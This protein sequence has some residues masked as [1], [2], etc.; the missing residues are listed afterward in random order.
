[1]RN[2][3][4]YRPEIDSLRTIAVFG[5]IIYHLSPETLKGGFLGVD[6]FFVIS[7]YLITSIIHRQI[8]EGRFSFWS[9]WKRRFKRLYPAL[10]VVVLLSMVVGF[11]V[12]P[13]PERGALPMQ[14]LGALFSFSNILLWRTTG[15][16]WDTSS[17]T[18]SL[19]HTW[20]LSLEEQFYIFFP[21][22]LFLANIF[23]KKRLGLATVLLLITSLV[24]SMAFSYAKPTPSFYLLHT[25]MWEL[26]IGSLLAIYSPHLLRMIKS[27]SRGTLVH[28][29]GTLLIAGSYFLIENERGFP[30]LY[31]VVPC[32][33]AY[34]ILAFQ[35]QNS[36]VTRSLNFSPIVYLGK[37]SYSLY[38]WHWPIIVYAHYFSPK[39]SKYLVLA[40]TFL[41]AVI[42]YHFVEQP[43]R[44]APRLPRLPTLTT[45]VAIIV[46]LL[47]LNNF[48]QSPLLEGLKNFDSKE[49]FTR[50]HEF[51]ATE[52]ILKGNVVTSTKPEK[53][54]IVVLGSSH[55]RVLCG[56]IQKYA[57][58]NNYEFISLAASGIGI[59]TYS[60]Q[61]DVSSFAEEVNMKRAEIIE[62]IRPNVLVIAGKWSWSLRGEDRLSVLRELLNKAI[63]VSET[64]IVLAQVPLIELPDR[65]E[66][67]LRKFL[68]AQHLSGQSSRIIGSKLVDIANSEVRDVVQEI[69][70]N[71]L[72]FVDPTDLF[73]DEDHNLVIVNEEAGFLY[74]DYNHVN[75]QGARLIFDAHILPIMV[76]QGHG[77]TN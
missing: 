26:L 6:I 32:L 57:K 39:P 77:R 5:V 42:S 16:Y 31:A 65:Y 45:A 49:S 9:F 54:T 11:L 37:I 44:K 68:I 43:I 3:I 69:A 51:E 36:L 19:L 75:D 21:I 18:I 22:F 38:L 13:N 63:T 60:G 52:R 48:K 66:N 20:S 46:C 35:C 34:L 41:F 14:A 56:P 74:A 71:R 76:D 8:S 50:G 27:R 40:I 17:E 2:N 53:R 10:S 55:A 62:R 72:F 7:G 23:L 24:L 30:G 1:M 47:A 15:G 67:S 64:V 4:D 25:R 58:D 59:T 29:L 70:S 28:L 73:R 12:L 61:V 33:G